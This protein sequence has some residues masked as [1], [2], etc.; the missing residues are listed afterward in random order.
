MVI[1]LFERNGKQNL[2]PLTEAKAV[3]DIRMGIFSIRE[4]WEAIS[5]LPVYVQPE[6]YLA[7]LYAPVPEDE[8][9]FIDVS[10][11]DEDALRSQVLSLQTGEA[12]CDS[13]GLIA[14]RIIIDTSEFNVERP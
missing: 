14:G 5:G 11:K 4:R 3:A 1:V 10:L 6:D 2:Y 12:L 7:E 13:E 8:Y 9:L